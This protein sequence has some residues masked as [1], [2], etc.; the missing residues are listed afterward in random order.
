MSNVELFSILG[1]S[2]AQ[3]FFYRVRAREIVKDL[4]IVF[5]F[6]LC[7]LVFQSGILAAA[8]Y[9][10]C[11]FFDLPLTVVVAF[12]IGKI[13]SK[14][15]CFP[16]TIYG[17]PE[18]C[19]FSALWLAVF[20]LPIGINF[21]AWNFLSTVSVAITMLAVFAAIKE[22]IELACAAIPVPAIILF[23]ISVG[24]FGLGFTLFNM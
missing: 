22:R 5:G 21:D 10:N 13:F 11:D 14:R 18:F 15:I 24:I 3:I 8:H 16:K 6:Y 4:P 7:L 12:A 19:I 23:L 17:F 2:V 1:L 9:A 20:C